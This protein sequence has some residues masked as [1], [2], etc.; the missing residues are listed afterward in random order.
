[1]FNKASDISNFKNKL[2]YDPEFILRKLRAYIN[3]GKR[4]QRKANHNFKAVEK[5]KMK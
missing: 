3:T 4:F 1:M 5:V 2:K